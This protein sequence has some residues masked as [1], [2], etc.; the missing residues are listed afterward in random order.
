SPLSEAQVKDAQRL[1]ISAFKVL[2][3]SGMARVDLFLERPTGKFYV[4]EI[5]TLPGFTTISMYSQ[6]WAASGLE[7]PQLID[8]LIAL[9]IERHADKQQLRTSM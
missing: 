3:C 6:L 5:N 4:N 9:A 2:D 8:R 7:Y 1:A